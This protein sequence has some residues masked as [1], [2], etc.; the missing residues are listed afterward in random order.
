MGEF[1]H[2]PADNIADKARGEK[3]RERLTERKEKREIEKKLKSVKTLG[4][5]SESEDDDT[6]AWVQKSRQK[7]LEKKQ[8]EARAKLL[9]ELDE[10]F[11]VGELVE[12]EIRHDRRTAYTAKDLKGLKVEHALAG[13][14][15]GSSVILTLKDQAVLNDEGDVLVNVNMVDD[16]RYK[17]NIIRRKQKPGAGME[18]EDPY[19][20][21]SKSVLSKYDEEINGEI[22][23][24]F[25]LGKESSQLEK[26]KQK[27]S[28]K[29]KLMAKKEIVSLNS[30]TL[31]LASDYFTEEEMINKF[32]KPSKKVKKIRKK[33]KM[34]KAEDLLAQEQYLPS[35][36]GF[37]KEGN[38]ATKI[39]AEPVDDPMDVD[40]LAPPIEDLSDV[41]I[42]PDEGEIELQ[43]ALSKA[44]KMKLKAVKED[45]VEQIAKD[46]LESS[47]RNKVDGPVGSIVLNSTAEFCRTLGDI[48]TYGLSGNREEEEQEILDF[49][50]EIK[51]ERRKTEEEKRNVGAWNQVPLDDRAAEVLP[52]E[53][54]ILDAEPDVGSGVAGALRLA[55]SKGY[56][57]KETE[58]RPSASRFAHLQAQNYSIED[59]THGD[60]EKFGRRDR[61]VGP[62]T[63][64]KE[65]D[66]Y[67]PNVKLDYIDDEGRILNAKEAFRY[68]SHKFHGKGPGKNKVEKRMKKN[69]QE[70]LMKQMSS[71]DTPLG[72]LTMLQ[73]KQKETQSPYV[74]LS[75]NK[76]MQTTTISKS[77]I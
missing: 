32:K 68:L 57:E 73:Q 4:E 54:P 51:E 21:P 42:E 46:I 17:K 19:A 22:V 8:A 59:K 6:R 52:N 2:K 1:V 24:S 23:D 55:L 18:D 26:I 69:E 66:N 61:Y 63:D 71:T 53:V 49:E 34:L 70:G 38:L 47:E 40:D 76:Q 36:G 39:K 74:V 33:P 7:E 31:K 30:S 11:G 37:K 41:K 28:I 16:E 65:K 20:E 25:V 45:S 72:T 13:F 12:E 60:E 56:L 77:K 43:L 27:L 15:E 75:G 3:I 58:N 64:F 44:R 35:S 10:E 29:N 9:E 50:R 48:P 14:N 62:T 67:K 5:E